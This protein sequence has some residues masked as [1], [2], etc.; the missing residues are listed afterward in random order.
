MPRKA[1]APKAPKL[2]RKPG[3][4][5]KKTIA[6]QKQ[7]RHQLERRGKSVLSL[8]ALHK[9]DSGQS[10]AHELV[11]TTPKVWLSKYFIHQAKEKSVIGKEDKETRKKTQNKRA[12]A[13][14]ELM[15]LTQTRNLEELREYEQLHPRKYKA[16]L[17]AV[18]F[19]Q[20]A[21]DRSQD[22]E[23][24]IKKI[25]NKKAA[26]HPN[27]VHE[28]ENASERELAQI[29]ERLKQQYAEKQKEKAEKKRQEK[30]EKERRK[31]EKMKAKSQLP[32]TQPS[33]A[34]PP[35]TPKAIP[36][37]VKLTPRRVTPIPVNG[38]T[39]RRVTPIPVSQ[40]KL[41]Q[42]S[43][44]TE[45][46]VSKNKRKA[47]VLERG[48]STTHSKDELDLVQ[49][50][51]KHSAKRQATETNRRQVKFTT[52]SGKLVSFFVGDKSQNITEEHCKSQN[53]IHVKRIT[54]NRPS[55][56]CRTKTAK[57]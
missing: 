11:S 7:K 3:A 4:T 26:K 9:I 57:K 27:R 44:T 2:I 37:P 35:T 40:P 53:K 49:G 25:S 34:P 1:K 8:K 14:Q 56:Y 45:Q 42:G 6:A 16:F 32:L 36:D 48:Y 33:F 47:E 31:A 24:T 51:E 20:I 17:D 10:R 21:K 46:V 29:S 28:Q 39:P 54:K 23:P 41:E 43:T 18:Q 30:E 12:A 50:F 52:K 38:P 13:L 22:F 5:Y 55:G 19:G 15:R